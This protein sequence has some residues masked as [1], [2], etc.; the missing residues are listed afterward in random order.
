MG[1]EAVV[2]ASRLTRQEAAAPYVQAICDWS[3]E[4]GGVRPSSRTATDILRQVDPVA[5]VPGPTKRA[6]EIV[7]LK[8]R[9]AEL[10]QENRRLKAELAKFQKKAA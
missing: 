3:A 10:E 2:A 4:H 1:A 6:N 9:V 8:K 7:R 5:E